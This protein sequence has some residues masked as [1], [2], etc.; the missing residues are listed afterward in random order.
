MKT[1]WALVIAFLIVTLFAGLI[2]FLTPDTLAR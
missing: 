2:F 1:S